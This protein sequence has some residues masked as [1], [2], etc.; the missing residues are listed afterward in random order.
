[1]AL[2]SVTKMLSQRLFSRGTRGIVTNT[3]GRTETSKHITDEKLR[4]LCE[5][6]E[7][8][9]A[10]A[11]EFIDECNAVFALKRAFPFDRQLWA[12]FLLGLGVS[13][14]QKFQEIV[15]MRNAIE[16]KK[17]QLS[18]LRNAIKDKESPRQEL[19]APALSA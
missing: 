5:R 10:E 13:A 15:K 1:M 17:N 6:F 3:G 19:R 2:K 14:V 8:A 12:S 16:D 18:A 9:T 4:S 11:K 7:Q